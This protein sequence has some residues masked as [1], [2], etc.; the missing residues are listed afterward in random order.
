MILILNFVS[1]FQLRI[2][3]F[4]RTIYLQIETEVINLR[5]RNIFL[6]FLHTCRV[7]GDEYKRTDESNKD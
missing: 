7:D 5:I 2:T 3:Y 1:L 6:V 4:L